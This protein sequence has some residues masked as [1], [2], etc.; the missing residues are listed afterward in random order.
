[1]EPISAP[2]RRVATEGLGFGLIAGVIFEMMEM[3]G[4]AVT[5]GS[6]LEPLR[7]SASIVLGRD[8]LDS[9]L[10]TTYLLGFVVHLLL[11]ALFGLIYLEIDAGLPTD[12]H[13]RYGVQ[14]GLGVVYRMLLWLINVELVAQTL[15]P[16]FLTPPPVVQL[17]LYALF[18][19]APL[20]VMFA[21]TERRVHRPA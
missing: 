8:A 16:W 21:G 15:F 13:E 20:G 5:S 3:F 7:M 18:F 17:L 12:A 10:G 11:S 4:S 9:H 14:L 6:P 1:M 19:G 2:Q